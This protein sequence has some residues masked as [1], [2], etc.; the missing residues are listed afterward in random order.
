MK[1]HIKTVAQTLAATVLLGG[2]A[3]TPMGP[4]VQVLPAPNKPFD[5][6]QAEQVVCKDYA[7]N[8]V[9]GQAE[10]SN[11]MAIGS[12]LL[13]AALGAGLGGAIGGGE[14]AGIGAASGGLFGTAVGASGSSGSGASIQMQYNN[15][16]VQCMYAKGNQVPGAASGTYAHV[17]PPP[18]PGR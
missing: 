13:A 2:C 17:P 7:R 4:T 12:T 15:A 10:A 16:Y 14:G 6:F 8:E 11:T 1:R 3:T 9:G 18:P 5:V